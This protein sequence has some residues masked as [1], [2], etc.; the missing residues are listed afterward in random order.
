MKTLGVDIMTLKAKDYLIIADYYFKYIDVQQL[1][2]K[3]SSS[4][5]NAIKYMFA[6]HGIPEEII[7]DNMP[8]TSREKQ[9]FANE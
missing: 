2:V 1:R 6:T 5:V 3:T 4:V 8:F 9:A 7:S